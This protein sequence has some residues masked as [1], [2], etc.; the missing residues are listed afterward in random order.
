MTNK[1]DSKKLTI[2]LSGEEID[3][4]KQD[5]KLRCVSLH[6]YII[7]ILVYQYRDYEYLDDCNFT[8]TI[9]YDKSIERN[10]KLILFLNKDEIDL[11][12]ELYCIDFNITELLLYYLYENKDFIKWNIE[13]C[14]ENNIYSYED[15]ITSC[16]F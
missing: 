15:D 14:K 5:A 7:D 13:Y 16:A 12:D 8:K 11:I 2:F 1:K 9:R 10:K 3:I 6:E 4:L